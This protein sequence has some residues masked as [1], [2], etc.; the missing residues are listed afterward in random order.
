MAVTPVL[1]GR[2]RAGETLLSGWSAIPEPLVAEGVARAGF[3][4]VVLEIQHGMHDVG[5]VMRGIAAVVLAGKPALVRIPVGDNATASRV[6]DFGAEAVIAPMINS[7]AEARALVAAT[8]YPP[9]GER[10]WGPS[11][12]LALRGTEAQQHLAG[13]NAVSMTFAMIETRRALDALEEIV[14]VEGIDGIFVGPSDLSV[15]LSDGARIA[16]FDA[17]LDGP[18]GRIVERTLAAGK[19]PAIYAANPDRARHFRAMGFRL[20]AMSSDV[21]YLSAGA[22]AM[23]AAY[24]A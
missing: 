11:R 21:N 13:D 20:I 9:V 18:L 19:T 17:S 5:S 22:K 8:K 15:S 23:L 24:F 1:A 16:P 4:A 12:V 6:L 3:D 7:A 2:L 10:S 14:A